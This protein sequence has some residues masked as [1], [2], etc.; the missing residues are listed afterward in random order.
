MILLCKGQKRILE[1]AVK[2]KCKKFLL[3]STGSC[4]GKQPSKI[5]N[6]PET[7][8]GAPMTNDQNFNFS[9]LGEAKRASEI[10]TSV[11]SQKFSIETKVARCF[12]FIGPYMP[13]NIH[14]AIGNFI[15]DAIK[16]EVIN[17]KGDGKP[18]RSYM[19]ASDLV[20]WLLT[21][22]FNG[23]DNEIYNVGSEQSISIYELAK[24]VSELASKKIKINL[25]NKNINEHKDRYIPSTKKVR[26]EL[27]LTMKINLDT[28]IL[29]SIAHV[30]LNK[31]YY[32]IQ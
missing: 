13:L 9:I 16:G 15:A 23:K 12:S 3:T 2:C 26:K 4:Y 14:Y 6:I 8:V 32:N 31:K 21:I 20:V 17:I 5:M 29:K 10:L 1:F 28:A 19:Y 22:L 30:N 7:Y 11:Y 18:F 24:K 27:N 25:E